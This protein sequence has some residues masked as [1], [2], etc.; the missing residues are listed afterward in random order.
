MRGIFYVTTPLYYVNDEPH[1]G[2]AYT[3]IL[4]DV[5]A[6]YHRLWGEEVFFLTGTDEH[7]QKLQETA[8]RA[9]KHPHEFCDMMVERFKSLW[10]KLEI[11]YDDF[12]R[13]T[14]GRHIEVVQKVLSDLHRKGEIYTHSYS[15][16]YCVPCERFWTEKD[17]MG[18]RCPDCGGE[19][20]MLAE[21]NYFFRMG[22][23]RDWLVKHIEAHPD[24]I[25]PESR[26]N[27]ILGFLRRELG[28]LCI[29]RPKKRLSWGIELPFD[30]NYVTYVW[31]D[32]LLN[33]ITAPG[34][35][36]QPERFDRYWPEALHLIGKDILTTHTVYWPIMLRAAGVPPPKTVLGHGWWLAGGTKMSKSK[37]NVLRPWEIIDEYGVDAFRYFL[38]R[39]MTLGQDATFSEE[40][41]ISR[42]NS[43]LANDLGNLLSRLLKMV[44]SYCEGKIPE[45]ADG[46]AADKALIELGVETGEKI[47]ERIEEFKLNAALEDIMQFVRA[48][49]KYIEDNRPWDLHKEGRQER[50]NTILYN[51]AEALHLASGLLYPVMPKKSLEIRRQLGLK[52]DRVTLEGRKPWGEL[53]WGIKIAP[54]EA[55]FPRAEVTKTEVTTDMEQNP[56]GVKIV[57]F[58]D[59]QKLDMRVAKVVSA[60][61]V[62]GAAKLFK[63]QIDLG[64][65][66]RQI[67]AGIAP[68]YQPEEMAGRNIVVVTNMKPAKIRGVES[69]AMLLAALEGD[70]LA[71]LTIDRDLPLGAK[72]S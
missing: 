6:R 57:S 19:V 29:S 54:G 66:Q 72:V 63:M 16:W 55:L 60:E 5:F 14:E 21:E 34:Y 25:K 65:E 9:G 18:G 43:D 33:Y 70:Q 7:G 49:N 47:R 31:F 51:S 23:Y 22:K 30:E 46:N 26:R 38:I 69:T 48:T 36:S 8:A 56:E 11:S 12:I 2:H 32:A 52:E 13:T 62:E 59:F 67:V 42:H 40:A 17:L 50:L 39:E 10:R 68:W 15:G 61:K 4:A 28:D 37:G 64:K 1:I 58:E 71:L 27:E 3:T 44:E 41:F 24:F 35:L 20:N 53:P 45:P